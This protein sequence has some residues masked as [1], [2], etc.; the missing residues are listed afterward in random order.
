MHIGEGIRGIP[1]VIATGDYFYGFASECDLAG[2]RI[3][4]VGLGERGGVKSARDRAQ[5]Q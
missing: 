5:Q 2:H 4:N 3:V 1:G